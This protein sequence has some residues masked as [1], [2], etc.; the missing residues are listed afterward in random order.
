MTN[1]LKNYKLIQDLKS[2]K[3]ES[4]KLI[5]TDFDS[6]DDYKSELN[7]IINDAIAALADNP[8][9]YA[10][11]AN[12]IGAL[13]Q[14][15]VVNV[16]S[17][18]ILVNPVL[19]VNSDSVKVPY[20]E[21][22]ISLQNRLFITMRETSITV[23]AENLAEP[24]V[25]SYNESLDQKENPTLYTNTELMEIVYLQQVIDSMHG[26]LPIDRTFIPKKQPIT[27]EDKIQR[28]QLITL[29]K[30]DKTMVIKF[31]KIDQYLN[32]GWIVKVDNN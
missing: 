6:E 2:L 13:Y 7:G 32:D 21:C 15:G 24:L 31:K 1:K 14:V 11:S 23:T 19:R 16:T 26:I 25:L 3:D 30:G 29:V 17:P 9:H 20:I 8:A 12:Q 27:V 22:N 4:L 5:K 18:I 28:N 10:C